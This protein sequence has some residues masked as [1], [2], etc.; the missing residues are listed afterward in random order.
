MKTS[1]HQAASPFEISKI[2]N[3]LKE[4]N[5]YYWNPDYFIKS[6]YFGK[7]SQCNQTWSQG[8]WLKF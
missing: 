8:M 7:L 3:E 5:C 1:Q 4:D 2:D 6:S